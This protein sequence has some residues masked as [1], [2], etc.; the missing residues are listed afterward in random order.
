MKSKKHNV[1]RPRK[2]PSKKKYWTPK[3]NFSAPL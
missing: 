2:R 1:W 3:I